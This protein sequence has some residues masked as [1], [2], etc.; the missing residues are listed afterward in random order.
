MFTRSTFL[1]R[2]FAIS[3]FTA[4]S[5]GIAAT[6]PKSGFPEISV[7]PSQSNLPDPL[8]RLDGSAVK[9]KEEWFNERRPELKAMFEHY[10]YGAIPPAPKHTNV[11]AVGEYTNFLEGAATL[12]L[13]TLD[14]GGPKAPQ[15]DL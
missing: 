3:V 10:M 11:R 5:S 13:L 2:V 15:I 9:S 12:K 14:T 1:T 8:V 6:S 4:V 7:L